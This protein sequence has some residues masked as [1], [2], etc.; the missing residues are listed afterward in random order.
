MAWEAGKEREEGWGRVERCSKGWR[1]GGMKSRWR[2]EGRD[3][4]RAGGGREGRRRDGER[5]EGYS[6]AWGEER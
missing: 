3:T 5:A 2:E 1:E 6:I 4:A